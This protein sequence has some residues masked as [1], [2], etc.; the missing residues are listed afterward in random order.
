MVLLFR[1][2]SGLWDSFLELRIKLQKATIACN[3]LPST[4]VA[5]DDELREAID[6]SNGLQNT[7][8]D[9]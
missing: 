9:R 6:E 4:S 7:I 2:L 1:I 8:N 5:E 3:C